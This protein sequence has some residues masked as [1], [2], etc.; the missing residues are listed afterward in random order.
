MFSELFKSGL[1]TEPEP[2]WVSSLRIITYY[3]PS[4]HYQPFVSLVQ[5]SNH[6]LSLIIC[7]HVYLFSGLWI[8]FM[9]SCNQLKKIFRLK[10]SGITTLF[11]L[12]ESSLTFYILSCSDEPYSINLYL[13]AIV[14]HPL[15]SSSLN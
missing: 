6:T 2:G 13:P 5:Y 7:T 9:F 11:M 8:L 15:I 4:H 12:Q 3:H 1:W 14:C 10:R